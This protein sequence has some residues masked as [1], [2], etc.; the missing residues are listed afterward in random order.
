M[1]QKYCLQQKFVDALLPALKKRLKSRQYKITTLIE[2]QSSGRHGGMLM[3]RTFKAAALVSTPNC[4]VEIV[5]KEESV[6]EVK[7]H[8]LKP[9][10]GSVIIWQILEKIRRVLTFG[11]RGQFLLLKSPTIIDPYNKKSVVK[12][13]D[14]SIQI[15]EGS[16]CKISRKMDR[17]GKDALSI[18]DKNKNKSKKE[19]NS[20]FAISKDQEVKL[21]CQANSRSQGMVRFKPPISQFW[22]SSEGHLFPS[23]NPKDDQ[24]LSSP[25]IFLPLSCSPPSSQS[26]GS[27][28]DKFFLPHREA[29]VQPQGLLKYKSNSIRRV[30][31]HQP[32][33][34]SYNSLSPRISQGLTVLQQKYLKELLSNDQDVPC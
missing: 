28:D 13:Q 21:K 15:S 19:V 1:A 20:F 6:W 25:A 23:A 14:A 30:G 33:S 8:T 17:K 5:R 2:I 29:I 18:V 11:N 16:V 22:E 4:P 3:K 9:E 26:N 10:E 27:F 31:S 32:F 34:D 24:T 12:C 7:I